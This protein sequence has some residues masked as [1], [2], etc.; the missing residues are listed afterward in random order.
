MQAA[1]VPIYA[2]KSASATALVKAVR[3][4]VGAEPSAGGYF[5]TRRDGAESPTA[6]GEG[7]AA[8]PRT[9]ALRDREVPLRIQQKVKRLNLQ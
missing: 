2:V 5:Q 8:A 4:L 7:R 6:A 9:V 3:T 1:G